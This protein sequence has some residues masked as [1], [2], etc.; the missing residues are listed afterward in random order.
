MCTSG[1]HLLG[2]TGAM[3]LNCPDNFFVFLHA[4]INPLVCLTKLIL[5][6]SFCLL[7]QFNSYC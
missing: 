4:R 2:S 1:G 7:V 5:S 6:Y 3:G